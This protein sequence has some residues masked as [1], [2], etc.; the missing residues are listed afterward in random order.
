MP[1]AKPDTTIMSATVDGKN[2]ELEIIGNV[3]AQEMMYKP[4]TSD[5]NK[6]TVFSF[7]ITGPSGTVGFANMTIPK[8]AVANGSSPVVYIDDKRASDQGYAQDADN[9]YVWFTTHFSTHELRLQFGLR[10]TSQGWLGG[11]EYALIIPV[12]ATIL[13]PT[14]IAVKRSKRKSKEKLNSTA[15]NQEP[16]LEQNAN[17]PQQKKRT[18]SCDY[19]LGYLSEIPKN[20][21]IPSECYTCN[22]LIKCKR[23][24]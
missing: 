1:T 16:S 8:N 2:V 6:E 18:A 24:N 22:K 3:T 11:L 9:Y 23:K 13:V 20:I 10:Q 15:T 5:E 14:V 21:Q 4:T 19:H 17:S 7:I 12:A